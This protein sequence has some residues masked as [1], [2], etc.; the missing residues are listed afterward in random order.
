M[1][2]EQL[3]ALVRSLNARP[4]IHGI[5]VQLPLPAHVR[6]ERILESVSPYKDID[7]FHPMSQGLLMLGAPGFRPCTPPGIMKLLE[8]TQSERSHLYLP[9]E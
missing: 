1:T 3:L 4:E 2:T 8:S 7:G 5:L 6:S 9:H